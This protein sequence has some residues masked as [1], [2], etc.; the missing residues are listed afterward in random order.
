MGWRQSFLA[1]R[2]LASAAGAFIK[3]VLRYGFKSD[4][5][6]FYFYYFEFLKK[7]A[8]R[9]GFIRQSLGQGYLYF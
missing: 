9:L 8:E 6:D 1:Y 3:S 7:L 2:E 5:E 4:R